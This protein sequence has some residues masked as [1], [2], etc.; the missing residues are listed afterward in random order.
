LL[1]EDSSK[2]VSEAVKVYRH[3]FAELSSAIYSYFE[4]RHRGATSRGANI[5]E[6]WLK[7][8]HETIYS[9]TDDNFSKQI[10][11]ATSKLESA[12]QVY[13]K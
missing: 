8:L 12:L 11:K 2:S 7:E 9:R 5:D 6:D 4:E 10:D 13:V 3:N 1:S